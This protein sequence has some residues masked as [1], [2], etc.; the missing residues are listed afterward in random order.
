VSDRRALAASLHGD[1]L[2]LTVTGILDLGAGAALVLALCGA[3][4]ASGAAAGERRTA[5]A[6]LRALGT[7]P[8]R[9]RATIVWEQGI[10]YTVALALGALL[11]AVLIEVMLPPLPTLIFASGLGGPIENGGPPVRII[12]PWPALAAVLGALVL[13]CALAT[14]LAARAASRPS[15]AALLRLSGE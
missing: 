13:I 5:L 11:G 6:L 9:V 4:I 2:R 15:L 10:V 8:R 14:A 12:W 1:P 7:A 3:L